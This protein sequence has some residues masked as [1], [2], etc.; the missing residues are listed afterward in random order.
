MSRRGQPEPSAPDFPRLGIRVTFTDGTVREYWGSKFG[1]EGG[2]LELIVRKQGPNGEFI[3]YHNKVY[4]AP[5]VW[6]S[7]EV[8]ER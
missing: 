4:Y 2:V 5:H 6:H 7:I 3:G 8:I 1:T